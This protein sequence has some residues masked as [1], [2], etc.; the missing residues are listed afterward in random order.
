MSLSKEYRREYRAWNTVRNACLNKS[1]KK[2]RLYGAMG[3]TFST[4]WSKFTD[5]LKDMGK[6]QESC[7]GLI[8]IDKSKGYNKYN[9]LWGKVKRG[10]REHDKKTPKGRKPKIKDAISFC[11]TMNSDHYAYIKRQAIQRSQQVGELTTVNDLIR[12]ALTKSYPYSGQYDMFGT[13][14]K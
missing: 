7:D 14:K 10:V 9:C 1:D 11:L 4:E 3:I 2:Y 5:F 13:T 6:M 8:L 12:E